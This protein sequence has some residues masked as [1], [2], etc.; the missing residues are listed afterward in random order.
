VTVPERATVVD[1]RGMAVTPGFVDGH[2]HMGMG[3]QEL[4]GEAD[5]NESTGVNNAH[6]NALDSVDLGDVAFGDALE[7]GVTT[8]AILP[9]KLMIGGQSLS[10]VAGQAIVIKTDGDIRER[11][12]LRN[13]AGMKLAVG[14]DVAAFLNSRGIGPNSPMGIAAYLRGVLDEAARYAGRASSS[15][16]TSVRMEA[17][18]RLLDG[19]VA[20]HVHVHRASDILTVLRIAAEY[21]LDVVLHHATEGYLV[22]ETLAEEAIPCVLGPTS[23]AREASPELHNARGSTAGVLATAGV[24]VAL[25]TDHPTDP[26]QFLPIVAGEAVRE[27]MAHADAL[28][29]I[30]INPARMW[31]VDDRVGS[32]ETGKDADLVIHDGDPLEAMTRVRMVVCGGEI[33]FDR[34]HEGVEVVA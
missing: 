6:L 13:P 17:L 10:P 22:T 18:A 3:W 19:E 29:A 15:G 14:A 8:V 1:A 28:R 16:E 20:A 25:M 2:T 30:T 34:L 7:S 26:I 11:E 12:L 24:Q 32:L 23:V 4:A 9:G 27:G 31:G 33:V 21:D 5:T